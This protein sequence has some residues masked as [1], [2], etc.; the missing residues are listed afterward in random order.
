MLI[1][2]NIKLKPITIDDAQ[3]LSDWYSDPEYLGNYHNIWPTTK[4]EWEQSISKPSGHEEG[5]YIII[6]IQTDEFMG[7]VGYFNPFA[8]SLYLKG[9]ELW[10]EVR[11][12]FRNQG[13]ATQSACLLVNHLFNAMPTERLQA[14]VVVGN[15]ASCRVAEKI[16]MQR[17]GIYRKVSFLRGC[18][19]D[20]LLYAIVRDDWTNDI[21][22]R[23]SH[24]TF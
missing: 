15:E 3:L 22:Y 7:C 18:Y 5:N 11:P 10:W 6:N 12:Q 24:P 23:K 20:R 8:L 17:D 19:V 21:V 9:L 4:Q 2:K 16:G 14:T 13:I 1:S